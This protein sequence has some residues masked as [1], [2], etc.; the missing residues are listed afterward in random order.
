L[1]KKIGILLNTETNNMD[2]ENRLI[3]GTGENIYIGNAGLILFHPFLATYFNRCGLIEDDA[4]KDVASR[5][6][7]LLLLQYLASGETANTGQELALNKLLC[8]VPLQEDIPV[9]FTATETETTVTR[10]LVEVV[11]ERWD[12]LKNT[13]VKGLQEAFIMREGIL[14]FKENGPK[15]SIEQRGYDVLLETL[16]WAVGNIKTAWMPDVLMVEWI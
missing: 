10:E 6:R 16:P 9:S 11:I 4:F 14:H 3:Q 15:L 13:S 12:K 5:N 1:L 8:N 7:A 2:M